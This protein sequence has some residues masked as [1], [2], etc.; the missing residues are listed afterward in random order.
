MGSTAT[1]HPLLVLGAA[2]ALLIY[3]QG[4]AQAVLVHHWT[5]DEDPVTGTAVD[6]AGASNGTIGSA[7]TSAP[8]II[9]DAFQFTGGNPNSEVSIPAFSAA[10]LEQITVAFWMNPTA[11]TTTTGFKRVISA[12]DGFEIII[13]QN[14]GQLGNNLYTNGSAYPLTP[15]PVV[16]NQWIHVAM[17]SNLDGSGAG[18]QQIYVNGQLVADTPPLA[19]DAFAGGELKFGHRPGVGDN[20]RYTGL[21]DDIRIYNEVLSAQDIMDLAAV[22]LPDP[23]TLVVNT[24]TGAVSIKNGNTVALNPI[25]LGFYKIDSAAGGLKTDDASWNSLADQGIDAGGSALG[26]FNGDSSVDAADYTV[27]RDN[28]GQTEGD[29]LGGNGNGGTVD[30]TDYE[31]WKT[32]FGESGGGGGPGSGWDESG[33][34]NAMQLIELRL[35]GASSIEAGQSLSLGQAYNTSIADMN[36]SFSY[37]G[38]SG[39]MINGLVEYVAGPATAGVATPEPGSL[40]LLLLAAPLLAVRRKKLAAALAF[41]LAP[42]LL[43]GQAQAVEV[44]RYTFNDGT[45]NDSIGGATFNGVLVNPQGINRFAAGQLNLTGNNGAFNSAIAAGQDYTLS[46]ARGAY[47]DLPNNMIRDAVVLPD[48]TAGNQAG[49]VSFETWYTVDTIRTSARVYHFGNQNGGAEDSATVGTGGT[50]TSDIGLEP[51]GNNMDV[52]RVQS[53]FNQTAAVATILDAPAP[54]PPGV[55]QHVVVTYDHDDLSAGPNGTTKVYINGALEMTGLIPGDPA[56]GGLFLDAFESAGDINNWLGRSMFNNNPLLDAAINEFRVYDHAMTL[57]QV[58][59]SNTAGPT[60]AGT[61]KAPTLFVDRATGGVTLVNE[62]ASAFEVTSYTISSAAGSLNPAGWTSIHDSSASWTE[63]SNTRLK[64]MESETGAGT[65]GNLAPGVPLSLGA[66]YQKSPFQDLTFDYKLSDGTMGAGFVKY[67]GAGIGRSDLN[68]DGSLTI[69]DWEIFLANN[70]TSLTGLSATAAYLKGDLDFD[71]DNDFDDY[72]LFQ[73]D[74]DA[75]NGVGAFAALGASVPEPSSIVL[76]ALAL[77]LVARRQGWRRA[78][79]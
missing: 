20:Q 26:D 67:T 51:S 62:E 44:H 64:L 58:Q 40:A 69:A 31:L 66:A 65:A 57:A 38:A 43:A 15:D 16:E 48:G 34:S 32:H 23:L 68:A 46:T 13:Q 59:S 60:L 28:L 55:Q 56:T 37:S 12:A 11:N 4:A 29:L 71:L 7:V 77:G 5:L 10:G 19:K 14:T 6:I 9:G 1:R 35:A 25:G 74:Y 21:L 36:L 63:Q 73:A 70:Y 76:A 53:R 61:P 33:G 41:C 39:A 42:L 24:T 54:S 2:C 50:G 18:P 79:A 22:G 45:A 47:V 17:T 72:R 27:W 30:A 49:A 78:Q 8:G 52:L 3:F 75:A